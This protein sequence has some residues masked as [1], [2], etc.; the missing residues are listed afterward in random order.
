MKVYQVYG[1]V[2]TWALRAGRKA[3]K[4]LAWVG[5]LILVAGLAVVAVKTA[6]LLTREP[7]AA[8]QGSDDLHLHGEV[9]S[10]A[11]GDTLT[12]W[13]GAVN[14]KVRLLG[15]DAPEIAHFGNPDQCGGP[16]ARTGLRELL[17]VGTEVTAT[18]D[19]RAD[20]TDRYGRTLAYVA[21]A[22]VPDVALALI[23]RGLAEAWIPEG[24][25]EPG[26]WDAYRKAQDT[27]KRSSEGSWRAC[28]VLGR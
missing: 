19:A 15:I 11:D 1:Q 4:V 6:P 24:E 3:K 21:S 23:E 7:E 13:A 9:V 2:G 22:N 14:V 20:R 17:P 28:G 18:T 16:E 12:I 5:A 25:P 27:A 26:R 8:G 10:V